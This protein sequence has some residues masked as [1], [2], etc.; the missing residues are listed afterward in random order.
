MAVNPIREK[1]KTVGYEGS[2][3]YL[4]EWQKS[5]IKE[6]KKRDWN[7]QINQGTH[8][9]FDICVAFRADAFNGYVQRHWKSNVKLANCHGS[10]TPFVGPAESAYMETMTGEERWLNHPDN[11]GRVFDMLESREIRQDIQ[12][13]F[14]QKAYTVQQASDDLMGFLDEI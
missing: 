8:A 4:G 13:A 12:Q 9:D 11:I 2:A 3:R 14:L 1:I 7:L 6:C 10:G 5:L